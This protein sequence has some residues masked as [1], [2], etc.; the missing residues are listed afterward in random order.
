MLVRGK[1][2]EVDTGIGGLSEFTITESGV[3]IFI[4]TR[5][6]VTLMWDRA[7]RIEVKA[8]DEHFN[9]VSVRYI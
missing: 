9:K 1:P 5:I 7:T 2:I 6:G 4:H 8:T 3:Y